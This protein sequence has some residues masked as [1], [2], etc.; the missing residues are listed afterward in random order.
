MESSTSDA[1]THVE[2][3]PSTV[4]PPAGQPL[5]IRWDRTAIALVGLLA[6]LTA[7]ISGALSVMSIGSTILPLVSLGVFA[8]VIFLL[9]GLAM[10]EQALRRAARQ[11]ARATAGRVSADSA[12]TV[13]ELKETA[14]FDGAA[15]A[16][17]V[18]AAKPLTA[19]ELRAAAMRVAAKGA[20]DAK[21]AHTETLDEKW[22]PVEVP[23][24]GYV[25]AAKAL[26]LDKPLNLPVA[27][28]SAGTSIKADQ[29]GVGTA[30]GTAGVVAVPA[31]DGAPAAEVTGGGASAAAQSVPA[32][33]P[34]AERGSYALINLDDVLQRRRA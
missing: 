27:P 3:V 1:H 9:R 26:T 34:A 7:G 10:R 18:P 14:L 16:E 31:L 8:A 19:E 21:L 12:A 33:V 30:S 20:A 17:A 5:K 32:K 22:E 28:K 13:V 2:P 25:K 11:A 23:V 24:P 6:L 15:G 29:A 4:V